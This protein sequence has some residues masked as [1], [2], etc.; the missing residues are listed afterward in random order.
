MADYILELMTGTINI[1]DCSADVLKSIPIQYFLKYVK[2]MEL[3]NIWGKL[4]TEYKNSFVLR[5]KLPCFSHFNRPEWQTHVE[6]SPMSQQN[7]PL[8][9]KVLLC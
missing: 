2:S 3:L 7:C 8:C 5:T 4:P 6:G 9:R 1:E